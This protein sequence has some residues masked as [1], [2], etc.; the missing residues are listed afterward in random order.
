MASA[1]PRLGRSRRR[2]HYLV[3]DAAALVY[4]E[5][6]GGQ[7]LVRQAA[8]R[9]HGVIMSKRWL[10]TIHLPQLS[11]TLIS[12]SPEHRRQRRSEPAHRRGGADLVDRG[13]DDVYIVED[14]DSRVYEVPGEKAA[15]MSIRGWAIR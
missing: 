5:A 14:V 8:T 6:D 3:D 1:A 2:R 13:G 7:D 10:P 11:L 15:T 4:E 12:G 9:W